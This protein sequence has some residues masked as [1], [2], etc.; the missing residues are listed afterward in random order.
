MAGD[1]TM[2]LQT[3][4][5][6]SDEFRPCAIWYP[7]SQLLR[8]L[9]WDIP[10]YNQPLQKRGALCTLLVP[11]RPEE[12][13]KG[14]A[15]VNGPY[16]VG[17]DI[18]T[19]IPAMLDRNMQALY[20]RTYWFREHFHNML[21]I[22]KSITHIARLA[23]SNHPALFGKWKADMWRIIQRYSDIRVHIPIP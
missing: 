2:P 19:N 4:S 16:I 9:L 10:F 18:R 14:E 17:F 22:S 21:E 13:S 6:R 7:E 23:E 20:P 8:T 12:F 11:A 1:G 15:L 5:H 3:F